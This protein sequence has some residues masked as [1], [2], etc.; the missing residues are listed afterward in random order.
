MPQ[1]VVELRGQF[2]GVL[3]SH[4][5]GPG[6]KLGCKGRNPPLGGDM[7]LSAP[8]RVSPARQDRDQARGLP[9]FLSQGSEEC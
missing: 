9:A 1:W 3:P 6:I 8:L 2:V 5:V 4:H 7:P